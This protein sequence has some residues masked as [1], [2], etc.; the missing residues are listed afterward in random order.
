MFLSGTQTPVSLLVVQTERVS[1]RKTRNHLGK[2]VSQPQPCPEQRTGPPHC[3]QREAAL[4]PD[5]SQPPAHRTVFLGGHAASVFRG[6]SRVCRNV[7]AGG[8][9]QVIEA[10]TQVG[11]RAQR[12]AVG[13]ACHAVRFRTLSILSHT[14]VLLNKHI[15]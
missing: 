2:G 11:S 12:T 13:P 4:H 7:C 3:F 14:Q 6:K 9:R 15:F 10:A 5:L 1:Q 8:A